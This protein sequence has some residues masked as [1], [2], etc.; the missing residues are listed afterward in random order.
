[1][2]GVYSFLSEH[3][4]QCFIHLTRALP[5]IP[6]MA[7]AEAALNDQLLPSLIQAS[8]ASLIARAPFASVLKTI[9]SPYGHDT[10]ILP[11]TACTQSA[12][13]ACSTKKRRSLG[14]A[15]QM[16]IGICGQ[17]ISEGLG[18]HQP[19][20]CSN[21][22][23]DW[24]V[25]HRRTFHRIAQDATLSGIFCQGFMSLKREQRLQ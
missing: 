21:V 20:T 6:I 16:M 2:M 1:M 9:S 19:G 22:A 25:C 12:L 10:D 8:K 7:L 15:R 23:L 11:I 17:N 5:S 14:H 4:H 24:K 13:L 18:R 3:H